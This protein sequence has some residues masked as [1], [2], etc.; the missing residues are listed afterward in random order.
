MLTRKQFIAE[1]T[2]L[3]EKHVA[4]LPEDRR[5][6]MKALMLT[7][8][9]GGRIVDE[10]GKDINPLDPKFDVNGKHMICAPGVSPRRKRKT[11]E[12]RTT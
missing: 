6:I 7:S 9:F 1:I 8:T 12:R 5:E 3:L 2:A 10:N 11:N 4:D